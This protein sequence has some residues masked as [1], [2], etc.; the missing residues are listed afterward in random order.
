MRGTSDLLRLLKY[1]Q[2]YSRSGE[3]DLN[4]ELIYRM[5]HSPI[6]LCLVPP[7]PFIALLWIHAARACVHVYVV[8][9]KC[10]VVGLIMFCFFS[11]PSLSVVVVV[12]GPDLPLN[13][14]MTTRT[15]GS[16]TTLTG[17]AL[18]AFSSRS[19]QRCEQDTTKQPFLV[20]C[21]SS[22]LLPSST[23][24][25]LQ[26]ILPDTRTILWLMWI[27]IMNSGTMLKHTTLL[28]DA[29]VPPLQAHSHILTGDWLP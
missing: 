26:S 25:L 22:P 19:P 21:F 24:H 18:S 15:L 10:L 17:K 4:R 3:N 12:A 13:S 11:P 8:I 23:Q 14:R 6:H 5:F 2:M 9:N 27:G 28:T 1:R 29:R 7:L 20:H 16:S